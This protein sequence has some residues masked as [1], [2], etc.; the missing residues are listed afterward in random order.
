M[1]M[2]SEKSEHWAWGSVSSLLPGPEGG[3]AGR[4]V[5]DD[6]LIRFW[7]KVDAKSRLQTEVNKEVLFCVSFHLDFCC[8]RK[9]SFSLT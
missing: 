2:D 6:D 7:D 8:F 1:R 9:I 4:S 5:K 3:K